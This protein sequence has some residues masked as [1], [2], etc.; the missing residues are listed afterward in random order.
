MQWRIYTSTGG[1]FSDADGPPEQAPRLDIQVIAQA[2]DRGIGRQTVTGDYYW[3]EAGRWYGGDLFGF[4]DYLIRVSPAIVGFG[5]VLPRP[6]FEALL[7]R[8]V[9][10]PDLPEKVAWDPRE[11]R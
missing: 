1:T 7:N 4:F 10:D 6:Q 2:A 5:R 11:R 9:T 3:Y 8:A